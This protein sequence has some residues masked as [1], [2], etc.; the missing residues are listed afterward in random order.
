VTV[1]CGP[2]NNG[3]DGYVIAE[4]LRRRGLP[5][6]VI[7]TA[8]PKTGAAQRAR[9][10]FGGSVAEQ[11]HGGVLVD[12]LFG[13]GLTR[14]LGSDLAG[15]LRDLAAH[16]PYRVALDLPSGI[17][18]DSGALLDED[19]PSYDLT[20]ALGAWKLAHGLMPA[21]AKMGERRLVP[22]G[23]ERVDGAA[24]M[25]AR[26]HFN[27]PGA[28]AHKYTR[29]LVLVVG[30]GMIGASMLACE[31]AVRA[32]AGA[33]RLTST[34]P[35]PAVPADVVLKD[36]PLD[37]LLAEKRT[38]A[39]LI[40]P[41]LG[42]DERAEDRL[43]AVL[44]A[45]L[46]T[47]ADADALTLLRPEILKGR[48]ASLILTPHAGEIERLM[49]NLASGG[50]GKVAQARVLAETAGA[51]VVAKGADTVVAA[52]DGRTVLAPSPSSWL[53]IAGTGDVLSGAMA[54]RL[55]AT[56]DPFA[57][58]CEA[59]WLHGEAARQAGPALIASDLAKHVT[60]A[61]AAAL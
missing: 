50:E 23:V 3:G 42:L 37:E 25:L 16:H 6:T 51:V 31:A 45:D 22:I 41:G 26:P 58:A 11:G 33:V 40:G 32:G 13:S 35:H 36:Q 48:S 8:E 55:A 18:S 54:A 20:I 61:Y 7:A 17:E 5:V 24:T 12:C 56:H 15:R 29:G 39:V 49:K 57:A 9:A 21:L 59:V 43:R 47:V 38:N 52:P 4:T 46:P 60:G 10:A 19:L 34:H 28:Y 14:P 44:A 2:G 27:A 30:G 1:L 53:A